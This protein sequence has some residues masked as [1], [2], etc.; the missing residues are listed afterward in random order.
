MTGRRLDHGGRIER[1][2]PLSF[3]WNGKA[4]KGFKGDTLASALLANG[5]DVVARSFK[6]H[7]P[8]GITAAGQEE[9]A[10]LVTVGEGARTTPNL[11][12]GTVELSDGLSARAQNCWPSVDFDVGEV[13]DLLSPFLAAGF[14]YKTFM[15]VLG[16]T[17]EW[18]FAERF[19]RAA[20]GLGRASYRADPDWYEHVHGHCDV[21]V[22]GSGPAGLAAALDCAEAG[23]DVVLAEQDFELGGDLLTDGKVGE[24]SAEYHRVEMLGALRAAGCVRMM[25]RTTVF[26]LYDHGVA[27][28]A[29]SVPGGGGRLPRERL[30]I[31]RARRIIVAAGALERPVVFGGNDRPGVMLADAA[32]SFLRRWGVAPGRR[33][34]VATTNDSGYRAAGAFADA[35][36]SVTLLDSRGS[37]AP[38][39]LEQAEAAGVR[40]RLGRV[41]VQTL[42][43]RAVSGLVVGRHAG[44][45]L[46]ADEE[47]L[48][49]DLVA[50]SGGW[51][52]ALH[53][54]SHARARP[55][56]R[57]EDACFLPGEG[58]GAVLACGAAAGIWRR[59]AC[60]ASGRAAG[61]AAAL[62]LGAA[63]GRRR[64][65]APDPGGWDTPIDPLWEVSTETRRL[66]GFVDLA[67]DVTAADIRLAAREGYESVE[68]AK[69][70]TTLG[71]A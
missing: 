37:V 25:P 6:Y 35:G 24:H 62:A 59:E 45:G 29:E 39:R 14:Y 18:M 2:T 13:N 61:R 21:L 69:R 28:L 43:R 10:A 48:R 65:A 57:A 36:L 4:L 68:H 38:D 71:M 58:D 26:G 1:D 46:A 50:V 33:A 49:C 27:G 67:N 51:S 42:G 54:T 41:P 55:V 22:V 34:A 16:G 12:P 9:G 17:R 20:A 56:W 70:Y 3:R 40:V 64:L 7:R 19:I 53:L 30:H 8:R 31:L 44:A 52:P 15:G 63:K 32:R 23:L 11:K 47:T 66:K 60:I 5:V